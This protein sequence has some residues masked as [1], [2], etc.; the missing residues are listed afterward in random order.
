MFSFRFIF[1][2]ATW[3]IR[4]RIV[5]TFAMDGYV[6]CYDISLPLEYYNLITREMREYMGRKSHRVTGFG[7]LGNQFVLKS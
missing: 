2:Q 6:F 7:H 3:S 1:G 4:E 5:E